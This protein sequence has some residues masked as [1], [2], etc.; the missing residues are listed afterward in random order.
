MSTNPL[1]ESK[2]ISHNP[3][4]ELLLYIKSEIA[5]AISNKQKIRAIGHN[6]GIDLYNNPLYQNTT[7]N[8]RYIS[9][10]D[11]IFTPFITRDMRLICH[12]NSSLADCF[13]ICSESKR[14]LYGT[15]FYYNMS[16]GGTI[17]NGSIGGHCLSSGISSYVKT[18]WVVDGLGNEHVIRDE[19]VLVYMRSSF[20]YLGICTMIELHT[21][22]EQSF[23]ITKINSNKPFEHPTHVS[24]LV[25]HDRSI[26]VESNPNQSNPDKKE[27][28]DILLEPV[29]DNLTE[30]YI[31]KYHNIRKNLRVMV[32]GVISI[33]YKSVLTGFYD[34]FI[35]DCDFVV[36]QYGMAL[37]FPKP[38]E[39]A[40]SF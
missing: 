3:Y 37:A 28:I 38:P 16:I 11:H 31:L 24:Q 23:R 26:G 22:P 10:K 12:P 34:I 7:A 29:D 17:F 14:M 30:W 1:F 18:L 20:G 5:H 21:F 33:F 39:K 9:L 36:N 25:L 4:D 32:D 27:Y 40:L 8:I 15:P 6:Y 13:K 19:E 35:P 2:P